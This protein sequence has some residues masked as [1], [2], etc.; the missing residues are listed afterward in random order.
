[1]A[2]APRILLVDD[3]EENLLA[4]EALL[5]DEEAELVRARSGREALELLLAHEFALAIVDVQMPEW[6]GIEL[7]EL[8][9]G[10]ARTREVPIMLVTAGLHDEARVF[11]GYELGAV[12]YL[13]K[14]LDPIV[15][16]SKVNV[17][18]QLHR[19]RQL[20][21][22]Q[23]DE[24]RRAKQALQESDRRKDDFL[25]VLSHELRNPLAP[26]QNGVYLLRRSTS[27]RRARWTSSTGRRATSSAS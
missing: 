8:M 25:A 9:R 3:R 17:F 10:T 16:R 7:A 19:Q 15:L 13:H 24:I 2:R 6:D 14:P 20:L 23:L 5:R 12:D 21:A 4:L 22:E 11:R 26:I 18:L 27:G 1:M